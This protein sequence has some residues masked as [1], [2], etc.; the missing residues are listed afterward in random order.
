MAVMK[1]NIGEINLELFA[2]AAPETVGNFIKL[3][4]EKFYDGTRFHRVI[5]GF[6][7]Q[8]GD[9]NSKDDDWSNDGIGGPGYVFKDEINS[10]KIIR[11]VLAMANAGPNTNGSQFFIVTAESAPWLD[12]KH[13]IFGKVIGGI[14][15]VD[16]IENSATDK[17]KNDHPVENVTVESVIIVD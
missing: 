13:T 16:K 6:M 14:D 3:S 4:K 17:T 11:G 15:V 5:K 9:P 12:G 10:N 1:T 2:Q 7:I 8:G